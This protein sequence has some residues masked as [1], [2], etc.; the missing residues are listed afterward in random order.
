MYITI[1]GQRWHTHR[2]LITPTF[3]FKILENFF[4]VFVE[5]SNKLVDLLKAN[6]DG[7]SFNIYPLITNCTLDMI[8]GKYSVFFFT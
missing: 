4:D 8:C 6:S 3:H 5:K 1:S 7:K 2:K